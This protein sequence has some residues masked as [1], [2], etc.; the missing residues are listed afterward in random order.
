MLW[1]I[2]EPC[3][4]HLPVTLPH[5]LSPVL[6]V[7]D[8]GQRRVEAVDVKSHVALVTQQ[9]HVRILLATAH[10]AGAEAAL[11]V[12]V[13]LAVLALWAALACATTHT[14][15]SGADETWSKPPG[16]DGEWGCPCNLRLISYVRLNGPS[17]AERGLAPGFSIW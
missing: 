3:S 2:A 7:R 17:A 16:G 13:G 10:A 8:G 12:R 5:H 4:T 14:Q 11:G 15:G 9:L 6:V 1:L